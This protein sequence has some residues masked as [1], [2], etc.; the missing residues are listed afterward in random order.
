MRAC[1]MHACEVHACKINACEM[2]FT[3]V[4]SIEQCC[5]HFM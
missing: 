3:P 2:K 5:Y 4:I 1:E